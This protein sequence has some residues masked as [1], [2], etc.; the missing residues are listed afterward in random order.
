MESNPSRGN[1]HVHL[2]LES[3]EIYAVWLPG[4]LGCLSE[5]VSKMSGLDKFDSPAKGGVGV[6]SA[7]WG[8]K[9]LYGIV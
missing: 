7:S 3:P 5:V 8:Y 6:V 9:M 1:L 4:C 2:D